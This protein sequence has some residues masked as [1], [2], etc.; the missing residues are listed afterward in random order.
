M[1]RKR[2]THLL[3]VAIY[4]WISS[5]LLVV[6]AE[7]QSVLPELSEAEKKWIQQNPVIRIGVD[8]GYAP[9]S[10]RNSN[11]A[12]EGIAPDFM[13]EI[14][15]VTGLVFEIAP[16]LTW[17]EILDK[18]RSK[19]VDVIATAFQTPQRDEF[20][21]FSQ[22]YITTPLIIMTRSGIRNIRKPSDL[23]GKRVSLTKGYLSTDRVLGDYP[24]I[25][26]VFFDTPLEGLQALAVGESDAYV[27]VLGV[28][29]YVAQENGLSN[30]RVAG[31]Y[32]LA[33]TGQRFAVRKDWPELVSIIDKVLNGMTLREKNWIISQ[34][35]PVLDGTL[36][37]AGEAPSF[38]LTK[39][40][41]AWLEQNSNIR[42][43]VMKFW[44]P[45]D[46]IDSDGNPKGIGA[47]FI[48]LFNR[49]L[50]G[51]LEIVQDSWPVLLKKLRDGELDALMDITPSI[52]RR[53]EFNFT[54]PY[55]VIPHVIFAAK[56]GQEY[57]TLEDLAGKTVALEKGFFLDQ[58][59]REK[60]PS[61]EI[62]EFMTTSDALDAT[63][64]GAADAYVGNRAVALYIIRNE[65]I[66]N[67]KQHGKLEGT[68]SV[69][70]IAIRK[71]LPILHDILQKTLD[72][73]TSAERRAITQDWV[74]DPGR[75][76]RLSG[77]EREWLKAH[78]VIRVAA[79]THFPP[80][81]SIGQDGIFSG[82]AM[83]YLAE[84]TS[85]LG[86]TFDTSS[87]QNWASSVEKVKEKE[88][89]MF[90][91]VAK[92]AKRKDIAF[93][94]DPY[95]KLPQVIFA[96]D[97]VPYINGLAGLKN[98]KVAV[99]KGYAVADHLKA[100]NWGIDILEV[101]HVT[102]GLEKLQQRKVDAYIGSI[103]V[104][105]AA[106]RE[107]GLTNIR[108][109][110]QT[111]FENEL[112]LGIRK[113]WP[114]FAAILQKALR[115]I[116]DETRQQI[117]QK[118]IGLKISEK[119]DYTLFWQLAGGGIVVFC[120]FLGWNAYLQHRM[121]LQ[122]K[123]YQVLE[124]QLRHSQKMDAVGQLTGGIAHDFNNILAIILGNL[125]LLHES[126]NKERDN[127]AK[128]RIDAAL[129]GTRRGADLTRKLLNFSRNDTEGA[130]CIN[131][132]EFV[133]NLEGLLKKSLTVTIDIEFELSDEL[134]TV[135]VDP[136][137]LQDALINLSIN[138]R[139]AMPEG[140]SLVFSTQNKILDT[141][142]AR[143]NPQ[144]KAGE[145]VMLS[146]S[147]TGQG[148]S[149]D[150]K[151]HVFEPFFTTKAQG[152]GT[153]LGLSMV[154][155]FVKRSQ[156]HIEIYSEIDE[157]T[158]FKIYLPRAEQE[159][160]QRFKSQA[161]EHNLPGGSESI[162]V[163][164]DEEILVHIAVS[165]LNSLG[166]KT[167][168]AHN[169]DEALRLLKS[170]HKFDL[171]FS[172]VVMPGGAGGFEL[173]Q[174]ARALHPELKVLLTSGFAKT[175]NKAQ[176]RKSPEVAEFSGSMLAKPYSKEELAIVVRR[177]IDNPEEALSKMQA[178]E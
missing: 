113:D 117:M 95:I 139:D 94:T 37:E 69:N 56:D 38:S 29:T 36:E 84:L 66:E 98:R 143:L 23:I 31:R 174:E 20:L 17:P 123:S 73:V 127:E 177:V 4:C 3:R 65:L 158:T 164:D 51:S 159:K 145:Y 128:G 82:I 166:Y 136:G 119:T 52:G 44:P 122:K 50:N 101:A 32:D 170:E 130:K 7:A 81:E 63:I 39:D 58:E 168:T 24:S 8:S 64:K 148:M 104:T 53:S 92:T 11:A 150:I 132:N 153:G 54:S 134:W 151:E 5:I 93:F 146:V 149:S 30:L 75:K 102:E 1:Y 112:A 126:L 18:T 43:G 55:L 131:V 99:V 106:L 105:S 41:Q 25:D 173:A 171:L 22:I 129:M 40:E 21:N 124:Q 34:W 121:R 97:N 178:Q 111:P 26:P 33:V 74:E 118:W 67:L 77:R 35:V 160:R 71:E 165:H 138:A 161:R 135:D 10:F 57:Q 68:A 46:Y 141:D 147:D 154:Y 120:I 48:S 91:A 80:V 28:S 60:H 110:G 100:G 109:A 16:G 155:G 27:G 152:K 167:M 137:D 70:A 83:D 47:D 62:K 85:I 13:R 116:P 49:R 96:L 156:G 114:E 175:R 107:N 42:I 163:V 90:S 133:Q 12:Y 76:L 115:T 162:L 19:S 14:E 15:K 108:V 2:L 140:G 172:D 157:G 89:D 59:I 86:V 9:Y 78:P 61:I 142:Y 169:V 144:A 79:D 176:G 103:L 88:L 87:H 45:M 72:S 6:T 125:E